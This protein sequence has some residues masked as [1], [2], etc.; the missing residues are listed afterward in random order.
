MF[1]SIS[2]RVRKKVRMPVSAPIQHSSRNPSK[3]GDS[4]KVQDRKTNIHKLVAFL[5]TNNE[6]FKKEIKETNN[7]IYVK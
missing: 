5:H 7:P 3:G 4:I 1:E 2:S 6:L